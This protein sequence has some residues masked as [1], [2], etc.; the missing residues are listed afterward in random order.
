V[1]TLAIYLVNETRHMSTMTSHALGKQSNGKS[2]LTRAHSSDARMTQRTHQDDPLSD[3]TKGASRRKD[4]SDKT[5][6]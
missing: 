6:S 2:N 5:E 4:Q 3:G 1:D